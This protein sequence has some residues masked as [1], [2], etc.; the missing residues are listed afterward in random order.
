VL[1]GEYATHLLNFA[2]LAMIAALI[3]QAAQRWAP[4][5]YAYLATAL[6]LSTP[7]VQLVTGSLFVENIWAALVLGAVLALLHYIE[8]DDAGGLLT[9]AALCGAAMAVKYGAIAF[10]APIGIVAAVYVVRKKQW[11]AG[12]AA[13]CLALVLAAPPY[14]YSYVRSGNPIFPFLNTVFRSPDFDTNLDFNANRYADF[15]VTWKTPF[16]FTFRTHKY[17]EG[18]DGASGFQ[19]FLLLA[20]ALW[21]ARRRDQLLIAGIALGGMLLVFLSTPYLRYVYTAMPFLTLAIAWLIARVKPVPAF[22]AMLALCALNLWFLPAAGWYHKDFALLQKDQLEDYLTGWSP[23]RLLIARLNREHPREPVAFFSTQS[24][25]QLLAP[26]Y[27]DSWHSEHYWQPVRDSRDPQEIAKIYNTLG[28]RHVVAPL[29]HHAD[30]PVVRKFLAE[31]LDPDGPPAG[32][33]GLYTVRN[34]PLPPPPRDT[35]PLSAGSYDDSEPRIEYVGRWL[36][37]SQF[38]QTANQSLTYSET[39]GD[40][41]SFQFIGSAVTLVYTKTVNRG[42]AE[43]WIDGKKAS[44]LDL[45]A[46]ST[47]WQSSTTLDGLP[48][49]THVLE[50]KVSGQKNAAAKGFFVDLDAIRV[51]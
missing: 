47:V 2:F 38:P 42:I 25:A 16:D 19:Y 26:A 41:A 44:A 45:Y 23:V 51:K 34:S 37:D 11:R 18:Q 36:H 29:S 33:L 4:P 40:I 30:F 24:T 1:G 49:A 12:F 17:I 6:F 21:F 48:S 10:T 7:V 35:R 20:P 14:V 46:P 3:T 50:L 5:A 27:T 32:A 13:A 22:A 43:V 8:E 31:W 9:A 39:A 15:H 28:I